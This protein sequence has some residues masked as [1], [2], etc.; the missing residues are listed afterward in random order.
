M[1]RPSQIIRRERGVWI[2]WHDAKTRSEKRIRVLGGPLAPPTPTQAAGWRARHDWF[3]AELKAEGDQEA[4][5]LTG[6]DDYLEGFYWIRA[7]GEH[8][9]IIGQFYMEG[10]L[11]V[12]PTEEHDGWENE[13]GDLGR[14]ADAAD[15]IAAGPRLTEPSIRA[16][17][18]NDAGSK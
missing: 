18:G 15:H 13:S 16:A 14:A 7:P 4:L 2:F 10:W 1:A 3:V 8:G 9:L 11:K 12:S 6:P 5:N 17:G